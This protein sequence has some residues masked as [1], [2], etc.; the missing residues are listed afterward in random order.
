MLATYELQIRRGEFARLFR[1]SFDNAKSEVHRR[2][3]LC[4]WSCARAPRIN[5]G[6]QSH[7]CGSPRTENTPKYLI[8]LIEVCANSGS[9]PNPRQLPCSPGAPR[10]LA[11]VLWVGLVP[12]SLLKSERKRQQPIRTCRPFA[13]PRDPTAP[14]LH[15]FWTCQVKLGSSAC[16]HYRH[17][18][19]PSLPPRQLRQS[20]PTTSTT[21]PPTSPVTSRLRERRVEW[22]SARRTNVLVTLLCVCVFV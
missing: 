8:R 11:E 21:A 20:K 10:R 5:T 18:H 9:H 4:H 1:W 6:T 14:C 22:F 15:F 16:T 19:L 13:L 2:A 7:L 17:G 12:S 3:C